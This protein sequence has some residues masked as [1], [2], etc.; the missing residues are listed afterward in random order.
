MASSVCDT[1]IGVEQPVSMDSGLEYREE[2]MLVTLLIFL[3]FFPGPGC[4][5]SN[6]EGNHSS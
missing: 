4:F 3:R 2:L 1:S 5:F 6:Q